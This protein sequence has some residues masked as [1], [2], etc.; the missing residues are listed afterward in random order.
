MLRSFGT[1]RAGS[2]L[3]ICQ[4]VSRTNFE[5]FSTLTTGYGTSFSGMLGQ[6]AGGRPGRGDAAG[7]YAAGQT[8]GVPSR[9]TA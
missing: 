5:F 8:Y 7:A 6:A 9:R 4:Q 3:C 2:Q 1:T